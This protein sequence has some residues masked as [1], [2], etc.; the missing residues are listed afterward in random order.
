MLP[1]AFLVREDNSLLTYEI[2]G[3]YSSWTRY[4]R[5]VKDISTYFSFVTS[6]K[7]H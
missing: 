4:H 2:N 7:I 3:T 5:V 6:C 1:Y